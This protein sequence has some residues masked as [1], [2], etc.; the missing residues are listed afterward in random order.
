M[1]LDSDVLIDFLAGK[2]VAAEYISS[3]SR[4]ERNISAISYLEILYGCRNKE[5]LQAF[6]QF[7]TSALAEVIPL[8]EA[9]SKNAIQIMEKYVLARRFNAGDA[10]IAATA[11]ARHEALMTANRKHFDFIP[12]LELR[13]FRP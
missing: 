5:E 13:I 6:Q 3:V 2:P 4:Q 12:G 7:T 9:I 1:I 8:N 11:L 10:L